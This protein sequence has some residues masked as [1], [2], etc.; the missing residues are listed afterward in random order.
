MK[1][2]SIVTASLFSLFANVYAGSMGPVS[3]DIGSTIL[4]F[5]S[6]E[7]AYTWNSMYPGVINGVQSDRNNAHWGGRAA[8]GFALNRTENLRFSSEAGWGSYGNNRFSTT[9]GE[10]AVYYFYGFDILLGAIYSYREFDFFAKA[11]AM[12][13][14]LRGSAN[15]NLG[16]FY[17]GGLFS[18]HINESSSQTTALPE[19]KVGGEYNV[20][21]HLA[22]SLAYMYAFGSN[23]SMV[24]DNHAVLG[25]GITL[26]QQLRFQA[27]SFN[28][29][30]LG[31]RYY[32]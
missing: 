14:T 23:Q 5:V 31:L 9:S 6:V 20:N 10:S 1:I 17:P 7:G 22:I 29:I 12:I 32:I 8:G 25:G 19:I 27:P 3:S 4:P 16:E 30:M 13:E 24:I 11:G 26:N 18:G 28:T 15:S 2:Q 21:N